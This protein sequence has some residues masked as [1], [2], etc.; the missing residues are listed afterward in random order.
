M[1]IK[2]SKTRNDLFCEILNTKEVML[3]LNEE[4]LGK[5]EIS[6]VNS[7]FFEDS[8]VNYIKIYN[9]E[10]IKKLGGDK[11]G[12]TEEFV[13]ELK[14]HREKIEENFRNNFIARNIRII[15]NVVG[16]DFERIV[17]ALNIKV[18]GEE[19]WDIMYDYFGKYYP[20][21]YEAYKWLEGGNDLRKYKKGDDITEQFWAEVKK[22][23]LIKLEKEK[24][25]NE[26]IQKAKETGKKQLVYK[27]TEECC[28]KDLDCDC[29]TVEVYIDENGKYSEVRHHNY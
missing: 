8:S 17:C 12:I 10:I 1:K 20:W 22:R 3:Y 2:I 15:V 27:Y 24:K 28:E 19:T 29:D 7:H 26:L 14:N 6:Y 5:A 4:C 23:E 18:E 13:K 21:A 11:I 16:C 25:I 9:I